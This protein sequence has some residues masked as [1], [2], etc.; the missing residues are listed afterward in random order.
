MDFMLSHYV[1]YL[2]VDAFFHINVVTT[3]PLNYLS[4]I[5]VKGCVVADHLSSGIVILQVYIGFLIL[6]YLGRD[7][8]VAPRRSP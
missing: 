5:I 2:S 8:L 4:Y 7:K 1:N 6:V 3:I